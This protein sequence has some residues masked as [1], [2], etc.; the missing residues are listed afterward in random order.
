[1]VHLIFLDYNQFMNLHG[2]TVSQLSF[3]ATSSSVVSVSDNTITINGHGLV[4]D[5]DRVI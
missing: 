3:D 1:M 2:A 5:E 4:D